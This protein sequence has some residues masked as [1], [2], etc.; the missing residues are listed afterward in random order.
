MATKGQEL[1]DY[2]SKAYNRR[3]E[4]Q[5]KLDKYNSLPL[6]GKPTV[7]GEPYPGDEKA[8]SDAYDHVQNMRESEIEDQTKRIKGNAAKAR[9]TYKKGGSVKARGIGLAVRGTKKHKVY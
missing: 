3:K 2:A 1:Q 9:N 7:M 6:G 5:D 8:A 4:L